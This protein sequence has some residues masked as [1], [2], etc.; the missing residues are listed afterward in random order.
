MK[1]KAQERLDFYN[2]WFSTTIKWL[3]IYAIIIIPISIIVC[4][5]DNQN[6][7]KGFLR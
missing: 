4:W 1:N 6:I 2:S 3:L 7:L 5:I